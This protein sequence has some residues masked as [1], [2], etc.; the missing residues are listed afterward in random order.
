[1]KPDDQDP[2]LSSERGVTIGPVGFSRRFDA[3]VK[4]SGSAGS[5]CGSTG[6]PA[7]TLPPFLKVHPK[8]ARAILRHSRISMTTDVRTHVVG[9]GEREAVTM[10]AE[11]LE[12]PLIG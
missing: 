3:L 9:E 11:L 12:D 1:M 6:T 4:R 10:L 7:A 5:R 8:A 2:I